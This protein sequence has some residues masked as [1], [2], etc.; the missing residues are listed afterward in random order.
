[1]SRF[2]RVTA[3]LSS[4]PGRILRGFLSLGLIAWLVLTIDW[5]AFT[6]LGEKF[7]PA[8]F[9]AALLAALFAYPL[10]A[11][12]WHRLLH[13]QNVPIPFRDAHR[14]VWLGQ[15]YNAFLPGGIGGDAARLAHAFA[16]FPH[17][18]PAIVTAT[19]LDRLIGFAS[20]L[21]TAF[22]VALAFDLFQSSENPPAVTLHP[23]FWIAAIAACLS[24][25]ALP[26]LP[27]LPAWLPATWTFTLHQATSNRPSLL[28]ATALSMAVWILDFL[29]GWLLARSLGLQIGFLP[30]SLALT[31][32]YLSTLLPIS[33]GGHGLREGTLVFAL[34]ALSADPGNTALFAPLAFLFLVVTLLSSAAGGVALLLPAVSPR[35]LPLRVK[36]DGL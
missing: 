9:A 28:T 21:A 3:F 2:A 20:L 30:L 18:R 7:S 23:A 14:I 11:L 16:A 33:L 12:R 1:M 32:A 31:A 17:A 10:C 24:L 34:A 6:T 13:A 26:F 4:L 19:L 15:F 5:R 22:L 25:A 35:P 27:R 36:P 8:L 29:S